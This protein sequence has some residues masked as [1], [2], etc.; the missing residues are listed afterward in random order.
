MKCPSKYAELP[1]SLT[2]V[3]FIHTPVEIGARN[4]RL[5]KNHASHFPD[6]QAGEFFFAYVQDACN[7]QC[8]K[9]RVIGVNKSTDTLTIETP[10]TTCI[11]SL[12]K[13]TYESTSV[14]AIREIAAG[15]G[16]NVAHP[17][18]YNCETRTLSLDCQGVRELLANCGE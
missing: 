6:L 4:I 14:E 18:L 3:G 12:S 7:K 11:P 8:S 13:V 2:G 17:L 9:V 16:I 1:C 15:I 10:S 5:N